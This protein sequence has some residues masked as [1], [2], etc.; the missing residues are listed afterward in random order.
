MLTLFLV[1]P[2]N[3]LGPPDINSPVCNQESKVGFGSPSALQ[4]RIKD[5][6]S[7]TSLVGGKDRCKSKG[8]KMFP[9]LKKD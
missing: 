6:P 9:L 5:C 3:G 1:S 7:V 2:S 4:T 8:R